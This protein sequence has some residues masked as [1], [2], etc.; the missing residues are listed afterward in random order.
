MASKKAPSSHRRTVAKAEWLSRALKLDARGWPV[1]KIARHLG[2]HHST[3]G[4]ALKREYDEHKPKPE[5]IDAARERALARQHER[6]A[7]A[8]KIIR[9]FEP[10]AKAGDIEAAKLVIDADSKMVDKA[11]AAIARLEGTD[12]PTKSEVTGKDG[13]PLIESNATDDVLSLIARLATEGE[14]GGSD[15]PTDA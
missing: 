4:A 7:R 5:E 1:R 2:L 15:P 9:K 11:L 10:L 14:A 13:A 8:D 3:V 6:L 12:A